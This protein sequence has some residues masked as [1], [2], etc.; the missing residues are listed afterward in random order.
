M[1]GSAADATIGDRLQALRHSRGLTQERL[2]EACGVSVETIRKL[3]RN[4]RTTA[5]VSTL[6]K[7]AAGL[8]VATSALFGT[9]ARP[10]ALR[11]VD[12]DDLALIEIRRVL[13]PVRGLAGVLAGPEVHPPTLSDLRNSIH[14][15]D[16]AYHRDDYATALTGMPLLL[17]EADAAVAADR[18]PAALR[19]QSQAYQLAGD[20]LA[21]T[22][23]R[24]G[25][26]GAGT[27][28][29]TGPANS[30]TPRPRQLCGCPAPTGRSSLLAQRRSAHSTRRRWR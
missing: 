25:T 19:L 11:E 26:S 2:A 17:A 4:E 7:L 24:P 3:E 6:H 21:A 28:A 30:L 20:M 9:S 18:T 29:T 13:S 10:L 1:T 12:D 22:E 16:G 15:V 27:T 23:V 5:R 14:A 8:G